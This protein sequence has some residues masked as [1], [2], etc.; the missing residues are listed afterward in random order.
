MDDMDLWGVVSNWRERGR[1]RR[2]ESSEET[3]PD[4][5]PPQKSSEETAPNTKVHLEPAL[6]VE[7]RTALRQVIP[8]QGLASED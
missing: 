1:N 3:A 4:I 5:I 6:E 8:Q 2:Q 7:L